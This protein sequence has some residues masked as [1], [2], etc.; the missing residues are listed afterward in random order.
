MIQR[1]GLLM[2]SITRR[3]LIAK[4]ATSTCFSAISRSFGLTSNRAADATPDQESDRKTSGYDSIRQPMEILEAKKPGSLSFEEYIKSR[5]LTRSMIENVMMQMELKPR[6]WRMDCVLGWI[7]GEGGF[8][9]G[10]AI[11]RSASICTY[12]SKGACTPFVCADRKPRINTY[13]DSFTLCDQVK[14]SETW[15]EYLAGGREFKKRAGSSAAY[16]L[17]RAFP[18]ITQSPDP[19]RSPNSSSTSTEY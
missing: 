5:A 15:Q 17:G 6:L 16:A 8:V 10:M 13:G 19:I 1:T 4:M 2:N 7:S 11:D 18:A 12:Q 9:P 3:R 14:E